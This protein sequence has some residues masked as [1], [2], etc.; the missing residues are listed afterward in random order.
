ME[1]K[2]TKNEAIL[3]ELKAGQEYLKEEMRARQ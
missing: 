3:K 2:Q 1:S